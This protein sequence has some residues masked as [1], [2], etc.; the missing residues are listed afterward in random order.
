MDAH[1]NASARAKGPLFRH[2]SFGIGAFDFNFYTQSVP[3]VKDVRQTMNLLSGRSD[4]VIRMRSEGT[5]SWTVVPVWDPKMTWME[6]ENETGQGGPDWLFLRRLE[7]WK[8]WRRIGRRTNGRKRLPG[9]SRSEI[10]CGV[11]HDQSGDCG[12]QPH[13]PTTLGAKSRASIDHKDTLNARATALEPHVPSLLLERKSFSRLNYRYRKATEGEHI[14]VLD[15]SSSKLLL[16]TGTRVEGEVS[17]NT[18]EEHTLT[19][20]QFD[21]PLRG[22]RAP[23]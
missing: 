3:E 14:H 19:Q 20:E 7:S 5:E 6:M 11:Q 10:R 21:A 2:G 4:G 13:V 15:D 1:A 9:C 12:R 18:I 17:R 23:M 22:F 16:A 8:S